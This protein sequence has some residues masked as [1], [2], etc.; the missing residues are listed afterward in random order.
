MRKTMMRFAME[1]D[2]PKHLAALERMVQSPVCLGKGRI[3]KDWNQAPSAPES[4]P[5]SLSEILAESLA[6]NLAE[7][8]RLVGSLS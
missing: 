7:S 5:E 6:E 2:S 1:R 8:L 4:L 3:S